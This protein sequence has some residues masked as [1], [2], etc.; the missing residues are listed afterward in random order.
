MNNILEKI[1]LYWKYILGLILILLIIIFYLF[2]NKNDNTVVEES[3]A[4]V[5]DKTPLTDSEDIINKT[6]FVDIKGAVNK[7]GVYELNENSRVIDVIK[8][9]GGLNKNADTSTINLSRKLSD[10]NV[11]IVYTKDKINEIKKQEVVIEY[12]EKECNCPD[13]DNSA[14]IKSDDIVDG[15]D[16]PDTNISSDYKKETSK[17]SINTATIEELMTIKG[18]GEAKAQDIIKYRSENGKFKSIDEL[19]NIK[20]IGNALLD[21]IKEY[22]TL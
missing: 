21:K 22:I 20:G 11:I 19:T 17:I 6:I 2:Y 10:G 8:M 16:L 5:L 7:P 18:I 3:N 13:I 14:C 1:K 4:P 12:I 9:A 15:K